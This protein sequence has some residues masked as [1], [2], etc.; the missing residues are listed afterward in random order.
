MEAY[1]KQSEA[2]FSANRTSELGAKI[3]VPDSTLDSSYGNLEWNC[4]GISNMAYSAEQVRDLEERIDAALASGHLNAW[5]TT[6]LM[7]MKDRFAR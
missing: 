1:W 6:F 5:Q 4:G 2:H 3:H 7:D